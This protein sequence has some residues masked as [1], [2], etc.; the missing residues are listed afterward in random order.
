MPF[1]IASSPV[2][3]RFQTCASRPH[4]VGSVST[5]NP[6]IFSMR[7]LHFLMDHVAVAQLI[8]SKI[9]GAC[10]VCLCSCAP[11]EYCQ[12]IIAS[13]LLEHPPIFPCIACEAGTFKISQ[14]PQGC[15]SCPRDSSSAVQSDALQDCF[16]NA[17]FTGAGGGDCTACVAG[18]YKGVPGDSACISCDVGHYSTTVA[19]TSSTT[20]VSCPS[21]TNSGLTSAFLT[22]CKCNAGSTGLEGFACSLCAAGTYKVATGNVACTNCFASQY[23]T[24]ISAISDV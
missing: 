14:G 7:V 6:P 4:A 10:L 12:V 19:A 8:C 2:H 21:N 9:N 20:C 18:K 24:A 22:N 16:C 1:F 5:R 23:S 11:N 3:N 17:G 13:D 15:T